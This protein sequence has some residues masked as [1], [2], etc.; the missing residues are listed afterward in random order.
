LIAS[1]PSPAFF[2]CPVE[3]KFVHVKN[4]R[5]AAA[6]QKNAV[7]RASRAGIANAIDEIRE[8]ANSS[9]FLSFR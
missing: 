4:C 5:R 7:A 9:A 6:P 2:N 8:T 3:K 1:V